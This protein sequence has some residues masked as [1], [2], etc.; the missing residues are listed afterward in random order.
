M[1]LLTETEWPAQL[2]IIQGASRDGQFDPQLSFLQWISL[3]IFEAIWS[4]LKLFR[5][6][7]SHLEQFSAICSHL[8]PFGASMSNREPFGAKAA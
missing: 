3:Q 5:A 7:W 4:F 8:G 2:E 6:I 1:Y